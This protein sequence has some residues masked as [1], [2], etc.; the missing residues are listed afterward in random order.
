MVILTSINPQD[1]FNSFFAACGEGRTDVVN[2]L[3]KSNADIHQIATEVAIYFLMHC[4][5]MCRKQGR[6]STFTIALI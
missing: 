3:L 2:L 6:Y 5:I 1:G 4:V